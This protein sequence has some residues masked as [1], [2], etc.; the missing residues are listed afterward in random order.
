MRVIGRKKCKS[1]IARH[2][3]PNEENSQ[4]LEPEWASVQQAT[5]DATATAL[6]IDCAATPTICSDLGV[7]S[8]PTIRLYHGDGRMDRYRGPRKAPSILSFHRRA[9]RPAVSNVNKKNA[10][11]FIALDDVVFI[12]HLATADDHNEDDDARL[13]HRFIALA[14]KYRDR[15]S[16]AIMSSGHVSQTQQSTLTCYNNLDGLQHSITDLASPASLEAFV[17]TCA[18]PL[19]PQLTRRN[20]MSFY[21]TGKSLVH[22]FVRSDEQRDKY[23]AEMRPLAKKYHE[24]LHFITTDANEYPEAVEMMGLNHG[25]DGELLSVQNPSNGDIFPY[26]SKQKLTANAVEMFLSDII[27]GK[28]K[29]WGMRGEGAGQGVQGGGARHEEL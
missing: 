19:I 8:F 4:A 3:Q 6:S 29:P 24:Y 27:Q 14:D 12:C 20:E 7:S 18:T 2:A 25:V 5:L 1:N 11:S 28:V 26:T 16:F 21:S 15:F 13:L 23:V 10:T 9:L 22:Y 17:T